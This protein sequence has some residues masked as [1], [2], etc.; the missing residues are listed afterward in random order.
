[1]ARDGFDVTDEKL[2]FREF[3]ERRELPRHHG[4]HD[5]GE[6]DEREKDEAPPAQTSA[7]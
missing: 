2:R 3:R 5:D 4:R 1:M 7:P 6:R